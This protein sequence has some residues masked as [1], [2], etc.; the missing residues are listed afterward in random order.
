MDYNNYQSWSNV[1][2][3]MISINSIDQ[4][5]NIINNYYNYS[6]LQP[7]NHPFSTFGDTNLNWAPYDS[8]HSQ[9]NNKFMKNSK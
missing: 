9:P 8:V 7:L 6:K 1:G 3:G 5:S 2:R 4:Y